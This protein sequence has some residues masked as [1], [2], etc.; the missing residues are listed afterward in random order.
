MN[1]TAWKK[2]IKKECEQAGTYQPFFESMIDT[3]A[4]ILEERDKIY[5]EYIQSEGVLVERTQDRSRQKYKAKNPLFTA[6]HDLNTQARMYWSDLGLSPAGLKK[7]NDSLA[8]KKTS[9][10]VEALKELA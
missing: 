6:W 8:K 5:E 4:M 3:L 7:I 10:I 1:K 9:G 2:K